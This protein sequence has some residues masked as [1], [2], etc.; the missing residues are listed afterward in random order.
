MSYP[1][2]ITPREATP[3]ATSR[4]FS[5][6]RVRSNA[7]TRFY[8][9]AGAK[10][11]FAN[12]DVDTLEMPGVPSGFLAAGDAVKAYYKNVCVFQGDVATIDDPVD[13][14]NAA[15]GIYL[16]VELN[17]SATEL[18]VALDVNVTTAG[19]NFFIVQLYEVD[20]YHVA[21]DFRSALWRLPMY[22]GGVS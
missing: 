7:E 11:H 15:E 22:L 18:T 8:P 1:T 3:S 17:G 6:K 9:G 5:F 4:L 2:N 13:V 12:R 19:D 14:T 20:E 16:R 10:L 21:S